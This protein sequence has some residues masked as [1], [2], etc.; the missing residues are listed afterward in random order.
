[1]AHDAR[2]DA[3]DEQRAQRRAQGPAHV[4]DAEK[5]KFDENLKNMPQGRRG[6]FR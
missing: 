6:G 3:E 4:S 2:A 5:A 1:M